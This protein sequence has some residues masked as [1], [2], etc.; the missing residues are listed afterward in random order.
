MPLISHVLLNIHGKRREL[1]NTFPSINKCLRPVDCRGMA[2]MSSN[3]SLIQ[4]NCSKL[5][6]RLAI[7]TLPLPTHI[8]CTYYTGLRYLVDVCNLQHNCRFRYGW[9]KGVYDRC[10]NHG[11]KNRRTIDRCSALMVTN[12]DRQH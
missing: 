4:R 8:Q 9:S 3:K 7:L 2:L 11:G 5:V 6:P 12:D 1:P 10:D